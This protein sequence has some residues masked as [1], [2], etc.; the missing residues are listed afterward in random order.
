MRV[1]SPAHIG[2]RPSA[3]ASMHRGM[4]MSAAFAVSLLLLPAAVVAGDE[5]SADR[6]AVDEYGCGESVK[7]SGEEV[8]RPRRI[9]YSRTYLS[10]SELEKWGP[11]R[12]TGIIGCDGR[13][14]DLVIDQELPEKLE[15][16]L[17]KQIGKARYRPATLA[18][19]PVAVRSHLTWNPPTRA[20][21]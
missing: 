15:A 5:E 13:V 14:H 17:R 20:R 9:R 6:E 4:I 2:A 10:P 19:E 7:D 21:R 1:T 12:V 3:R 11:V 18:S 8:K 16:K